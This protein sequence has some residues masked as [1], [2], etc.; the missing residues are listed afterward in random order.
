MFAHVSTRDAT[1]LLRDRLIDDVDAHGVPA[2]D[3]GDGKEFC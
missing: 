1:M 2:L 3:G